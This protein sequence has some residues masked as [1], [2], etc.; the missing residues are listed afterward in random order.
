MHLIELFNNN[1]NAKNKFNMSDTPPPPSLSLSVSLLVIA[2]QN[3]EE[4]KF[5]TLKKSTCAC[6]LFFVVAFFFTHTLTQAHL[7]WGFHK[8][9]YI[10][11]GCC[12]CCCCCSHDPPWVRQQLK[13]RLWQRL[14]IS[15]AHTHTLA[16][17]FRISFLYTFF[18][19]IYRK[20][21]TKKKKRIIV[22]S[23]S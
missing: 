21:Q 12:C 20:R 3:K 8:F 15:L 14:H 18:E 5:G 2:V 7:F 19:N 9:L 4:M 22:V 11:C 16:R 6:L 17:C 10:D 1:N 13:F 23:F